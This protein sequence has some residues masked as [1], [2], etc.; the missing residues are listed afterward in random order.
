MDSDDAS[1]YAEKISKLEREQIDFLKLSKEQITVVK[2]TLRSMN[3]T[4]IAVSE[5]EKVLAKGLEQMAKHVNKHDGEMKDMLTATSMLL[6]TNEHTIQLERAINEGKREYSIL[7]EAVM[8]SQKGIL[9]PHIITP[10][11]IVQ[12]MKTSQ[13]DIPS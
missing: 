13:A 9:Q 7:I 4:L 10:A 12:Q 2:S 5:N 8:N 1:Y 3:S 6:A 11:Q